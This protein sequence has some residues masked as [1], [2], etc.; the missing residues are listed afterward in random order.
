M[1]MKGVLFSESPVIFPVIIW[2][3]VKERSLSGSKCLTQSKEETMTQLQASAIVLLR[4]L[5]LSVSLLP[6]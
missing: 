4:L 1:E 6:S 2:K 3:S 5:A